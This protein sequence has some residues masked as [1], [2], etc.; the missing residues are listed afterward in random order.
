MVLAKILFIFRYLRYRLVA[1]DE[2]ALHSPFVFDLYTGVICDETPFYIYEV[3]E[4]IRAEMLLSDRKIIVHD[5][6]TGGKKAQTQELSLHFI[7]KHYLKSKKYGQ[8]LFRMVNRFQPSFVLELGTS[9]GITTLYLASPSGKASIITL[10]G[11]PN[12]A[13][14]AKNNFRIAGVRNI[15]SITGE[16]NSSLTEALNKVPRLDF[17]YFDGNHEEEA[18]LD[19]F[20]RCLTRHDE[21]S[22]FVFDDIHWS[23]GMQ[24]AWKRIQLHENVTLTIDLF[25]V[26]IVFFRTGI[27][28]QHYILK[29]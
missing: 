14:A 15:L 13:A 7:T 9:L 23:G 29:F 22:V 10:E 17:V 16:F 19:Y 28:K 4:S 6:G 11:C 5:F 18:T 20:N 1:R 25:R 26:G 8:L 2:H 3:I 12:T 21:N 24:K 27:P